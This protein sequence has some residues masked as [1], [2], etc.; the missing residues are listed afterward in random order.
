MIVKINDRFLSNMTG[1]HILKV[2]EIKSKD[3]FIVQIEGTKKRLLC[4]SKNHQLKI[5]TSMEINEDKKL[6]KLQETS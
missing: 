4:S 3:F 6:Y 1:G 5:S 2:I